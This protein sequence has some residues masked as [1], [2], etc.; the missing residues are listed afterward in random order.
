VQTAAQQYFNRNANQLSISQSAVI[1][2]ILRSPGL[3]DPVLSEAN[4]KRLDGRFQYVIQGMLEKKWIT[5]AEAKAAK[6]PVVSP[7][8]TSGQLSG[9][10]GYIID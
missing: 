2:S 4:K 7:R 6:M 8:T 1:A 3:Y 9:P 10:K 5:P